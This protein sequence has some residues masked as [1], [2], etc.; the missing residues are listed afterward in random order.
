MGILHCSDMNDD[1]RL[2]SIAAASDKKSFFYVS[3]DNYYIADLENSRNITYYCD[4]A[5]SC[6]IMIAVS[7]DKKKAII[8][9][10]SRSGR[11]KKYFELTEKTFGDDKNVHIYA[12][13]ANPPEDETA[14]NNAKQVSEWI[15]AMKNKGW[16][17]DVSFEKGYPSVYENNLDCYG[18]HCDESGNITVNNDRIGL[19]MSQRDPDGGLQTLFCVYGDK[20]TIREQT[21]K[22]S[23]SDIDDWV[24]KARS[25]EEGKRLDKAVD[26][27]DYD[28]LHHFS[29]TP[30][31]EVPWF[32]ESIR[33]A[34]I[35]VKNYKKGK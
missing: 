32:C 1:K 24:E 12:A 15:S 16:T 20:D 25:A 19:T 2:S 18:L 34:G 29:S 4:S 35:F 13:G 21:S 11:F 6:I 30:D 3:Q 10:L 7:G 27:S 31:Y 17:A 23:E 22:F 28:I 8:S 26:M 9:H 5:T 33:M 14:Q